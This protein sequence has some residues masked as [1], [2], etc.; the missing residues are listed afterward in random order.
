MITLLL[1]HILGDLINTPNIFKL[2]KC[3]AYQKSKDTNRN[4]TKL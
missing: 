1:L 3:L 2:Y 4:K